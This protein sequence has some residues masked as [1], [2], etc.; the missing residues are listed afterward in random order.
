MQTRQRAEEDAAPL[1][2]DLREY[3]LVTKSLRSPERIEAS[4]RNF[5][6]VKFYVHVPHKKETVLFCI[7]TLLL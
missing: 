6:K 1:S 5:F 3:C 7:E 4:S 2:S